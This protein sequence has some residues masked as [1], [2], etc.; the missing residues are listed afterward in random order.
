MSAQMTRRELQKETSI[1][2][3]QKAVVEADQGILIAQKK[4]EQAIKTSEGDSKAMS[5]RADGEAAAIT[6]RASANAA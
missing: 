2:D 1:A 4:A 5:I 3:M 6:K